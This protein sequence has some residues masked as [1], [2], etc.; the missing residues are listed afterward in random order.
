MMMRP[1]VLRVAGTRAPLFVKATGS[2]LGN[3]RRPRPVATATL[4]NARNAGKAR[5]TDIARNARNAR[6]ARTARNAR[7]A[8]NARIAR[9]KA[10][11]IYGYGCDKFK[12]ATNARRAVLEQVKHKNVSDVEVLCN[13]EQPNTMTYDIW[14]VLRRVHPHLEPTKFVVNV[15]AKVCDALS[16]GYEVLLIGHSYGGS[17]VSRV[18]IFLQ[19]YCKNVDLGRLRCA[20]FGS[21]FV[22]PPREGISLKHYAYDNDIAQLCSKAFRGTSYVTHMQPRTRQGPVGSHM[23]YDHH[24][25]DLVKR[26]S[27][28]LRNVRAV[29]TLRYGPMAW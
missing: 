6:N 16:R 21:I 2:V 9:V 15:M 20:T 27:T 14:N 3:P 13:T 11:V 19:E 25:Y 8:G 18:S 26:A 22:P 5:T 23:D 28:N 24:I 1:G 7:N 10:F 4:R 17:V 29:R 12:K